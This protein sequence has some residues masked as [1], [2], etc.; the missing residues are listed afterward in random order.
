MKRLANKPFALIGINSDRDKDKLRA[1]M[2][3]E[4]IT[5]RSFWNGPLGTSGPLSRS[6]GVRSWPTI[7]VLD[8]QG[9]IRYKNV[10]GKRMDDAV[11]ELI[12]RAIVTLVQ[13]LQSEDPEVRGLAAFRVGRFEAPNAQ[14]ILKGLLKNQPELVRKRAA[15]GLALLGEPTKSLLPLIRKSVGDQ[16]AEVRVASLQVL[17]KAR[18]R[19][20]TTLAINALNDQNILVRRTAVA[21]LGDL[22]DPVATPALAK[23]IDDEDFETAKAAA[24]SLGRL[25]SDKSK[26]LLKQLAAKPD[27]TVRV[28]IAVALHQQREERT[29]E[30]FR[31]L[32]NDKDPNIR[33]QIVTA[34]T[35]L[36]DFDAT[37]LYI[38]AL[39]DKDSQ[40][41][42]TSRLGLS[43]SQSPKA[44]QALTAHIDHELERLVPL[45]AQRDRSALSEIQNLGPAAAPMLLG[46][47]EKAP[48]TAR[49]VIATTIGRSR[50]P[51]VIPPTLQKLQ[52]V[53][54]DSRLRTSY[55]YILRYMA[56]E[57]RDAVEELVQSEHAEVRESGVRLLSNYADAKGTRALKAALN[58][59]SAHVRAY[60]AFGLASRKDPDALSVLKQSTKSSD[61]TVRRLAVS[62]VSRFDAKTALPILLSLAE[63]GESSL[64]SALVAAL[65]NFKDKK[66]TAGI[67]DVYKRYPNV[68]STVVY[69]LQRQNT[70]EAARGLGE[71]LTD[72][73][74]SVQSRARLSLTRMRIPDAKKVLAQ[75]DKKTN[76]EKVKKKEPTK[77]PQASADESE[78][79]KQIREHLTKRDA[80]AADKA[81]TAALK[82][83]PDS[84]RLKSLHYSLFTA[85]MNSRKYEAGRKHLD[86]Y[87]NYRLEQTRENPRNGRFLANSVRYIRAAYTRSGL[88]DRVLPRFDE[89]ITAV[90]SIVV[91]NKTHELDATLADLRG[92][93]LQYLVS[94][95]RAADAEKLLNTELDSARKALQEKPA[96]VGVALRL[97]NL[98]RLRPMVVSKTAPEKED[99]A[100]QALQNLLNAQLQKHKDNPQMV[101]AY[102]SSQSRE[103]NSLSRKNPDA[104]EKV[105]AATREFIESVKSENASIKRLITDSRRTLSGY[106]RTIA[107]TKKR[108]SLIGKPSY[109]LD[110]EAWVN[111]QLLSDGDLEGKV[112]LLD[113]WAVWCGP[114]IATFPHLRE[115][116]ERYSDKGLV[117]IGMTRY[118]NYDWDEESNRPKRVDT[119]EKAFTPQ[120]EQAAMVKFAEHHKLKHPFAVMPRSSKFSSNYGVTGIPQVVVI[121]RKGTVR[122][123]RVGSGE[124]NA[125]DVEEMIQ[126]LLESTDAAAGQQ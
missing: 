123:I 80:N 35:D 108:L 39:E 20:A 124:Q 63:N 44:K 94:T 19:E 36:T 55:E 84:P 45:L 93:K 87:I 16:E 100:R 27:H 62:G 5:W 105:L 86:T 50:N 38:D 99:D 74:K 46:R 112:V 49:M 109:P 26:S 9:V 106:E 126:N 29:A 75:A 34:F 42:K 98:M 41:R 23:A 92:E 10:R 2:A 53:K 78:L 22:N 81:L 43:R 71:L 121:D 104:A 25:D 12:E 11:D 118:Y 73:N 13:N 52:N 85:Y 17:G 7:Y 77:I 125:R 61:T 8:D 31:S 6:W 60:A 32:L 40:V 56:D 97:I 1:R 103:I 70:A 58:D 65:G 101:S 48:T 69:A 76:K 51:I 91:A 3:E 83:H 114:C 117:I 33:R 68:A 14:K 79:Y 59:D 88:A 30:R 67:M 111:G 47:L 15:T 4:D 64:Y 102:L 96:D 37:D 57:A 115:W 21:T 113:F 72:K 120:D 110:V 90:E 18:D 66:A 119:K 24:L 28:W 107:A 82:E 95:N 122:L 89:I 116:R 54:L